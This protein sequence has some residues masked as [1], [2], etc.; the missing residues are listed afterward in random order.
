M[1]T[2]DSVLDLHRSSYLK[3][4]GTVDIPYIDYLSAK[5]IN[6]RYKV[7]PSM[8]YVVS[9]SDEANAPGIAYAVYGNTDYWWVVCLYNGIIDP[10]SEFTPGRKLLLPSMADINNLLTSQDSSLVQTITTI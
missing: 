6:I 1:P 9:E 5:Y 2:V 3:A 8:S 10:V 7:A 4:G